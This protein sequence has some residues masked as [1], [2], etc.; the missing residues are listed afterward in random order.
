MFSVGAKHPDITAQREYEWRLMRDTY[1]G[2]ER[3]K[4]QGEIYLPK[5]SGFKTQS[6]GGKAAYDSYKLRAILPEYVAPTVAALL[7][8]VHAREF[9]IAMPDEL[10]FIEEN[11]DGKGTPREVFHQRITRNL[12]LMGR[13]GILADAPENGG[14]PFLQGYAAEAIINWDANFYVLNETYLRRDRFAWHRTPRFRVLE[15]ADNRYRVTLY[16]GDNESAIEQWEPRAQGGQPLASIPFAVATARDLTPEIE[17]PP[18]IG[19]A[20]AAIS[21]YQLSADYRHQLYMSGQE[22]LVAINGDAPKAVGAG[23]VHVMKGSS[24]LVPDLKYVSPTCSGINAH[25]EAIAEQR[26]AAMEAGARM[27]QSGHAQESGEARRM[28]FASEMANLQSIANLSAALLESGLRNIALFMDL[29]PAD[30]VVTP[31]TDLLDRTMTAQELQA[32]FNV[33]S[34]G[35]MSWQTYYAA[36]Q[37]GGLMSAE[38]TADEEFALIDN[39]AIPAET[40]I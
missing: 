11:I 25:R 7:G 21:A 14:T 16:E 35:G 39:Q 32:L 10:A 29:D 9:Q 37:R 36:A 2:Q 5:P 17:T 19:V 18:L 31:P 23:V 26:L 1:S 28:R 12:L 24:D 33:Y 22:T 4:A 15:I 3:V 20:Q 30:V 8:I 13:Y 6:D 38:R 40:A 27:F 34:A